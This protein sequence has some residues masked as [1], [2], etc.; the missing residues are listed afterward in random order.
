MSHDQAAAGAHLSDPYGFAAKAP[1]RLRIAG[2]GRK[3]LG[4]PGPPARRHLVRRACPTRIGGP[5]RSGVRGGRERTPAPDLPGDA[6]G[7][8]SSGCRGRQDVDARR[9]SR[10]PA[11]RRTRGRSDQPGL[12]IG[13]VSREGGW[14]LLLL[15]YPRSYRTERG[16]EMLDALLADD[17]RQGRLSA[18]SEAMSL[19]VH[20]LTQR[21]RLSPRAVAPS[22][23]LA[24]VSLLALLALL[25][26]QQLAATAVRGLGLDR[27]PEEW[28]LGVLWVDPRW[29]VH[30]LWLATGL[31]LLLGRHRL[32]VMSAWAAAV[33]HSWLL[34]VTTVTTVALPWP[35]DLG[36]HWV[37]PGGVAEASWALLSVCGAVMVGGPATAARARAGLPVRPWSAV[38]MLAVTG[39]ALAWLAGVTGFLWTGS[40]HVNLLD[41]SLG[42][43]APLALAAAVLASGLRRTRHGRRALFV[44]AMLAMAPLAARWSDAMVG[45]EVGTTLFAAGYACSRW[46]RRPGPSTPS[47][48]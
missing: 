32:L 45:F 9:Q 24:G 21:L 38:A 47:R 31:A 28:G 39:A 17:D 10:S 26:A 33:L 27:F 16:Q 18:M 44:V 42:Q 6:G 36:P 15:C 2:R 14:R 34:V 8:G 4:W 19:V 25:G 7:L 48:A 29:P 41:G 35:G 37:A 43:V 46:H 11:S 40:Y 22:I 1:A 12:G 30:V 20:G 13:T 3:R 23:G 5:R